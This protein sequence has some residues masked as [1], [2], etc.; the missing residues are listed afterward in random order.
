MS[1][2]ADLIGQHDHD[3]AIS[4]IDERMCGKAREAATMADQ[5]AVANVG[6][7]EPQTVVQV[8]LLNFP[9]WCD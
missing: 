9:M 1:R 2:V 6:Q 4:R 3:Q 5:M 7:V 8:G